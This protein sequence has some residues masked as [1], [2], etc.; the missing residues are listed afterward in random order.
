VAAPRGSGRRSTEGHGLLTTAET[1]ATTLARFDEGWASL[2]KTVK[3]LGEREL[4]EIRDPAGWSAKDHLM[5]VAVWEQ[6]LLAKLDGRLRHQALGL[7]AAT[8]G[9]EDYDGLNAAIFEKTRQRSLKDVLD[10]VRPASR[11]DQGAGRKPLGGGG[12]VS[13][14]AS[15][16]AR[17]GAGWV[18]P[19]FAAE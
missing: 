4:T 6:A 19:T 8:D 16:S 7:D 9:S 17:R 3:S 15:G 2:D 13:R 10:E 1:A 5:H 11:L 14:R 18:T 12:A